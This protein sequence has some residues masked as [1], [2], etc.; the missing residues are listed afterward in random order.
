MRVHEVRYGRADSPCFTRTYTDGFGDVIREER[1]GAN[2]APLVT[3]QRTRLSGLTLATNSLTIT[4]DILGNENIVRNILAPAIQ[5]SCEIKHT[6]GILNV[7]TNWYTDGVMVSNISHSGVMTQIR[8]DALRRETARIDGR[9]NVSRIE[10]DGLGRVAA[11]IDALTN[12]TT[13][14]YDAMNRV[15]AITNALGDADE[16]H[17]A[18]RLHLRR[19]EASRRMYALS[20]TGS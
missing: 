19:G 9:G 16:R 15:A 1:S 3:A 17:L 6:P 7:A 14:A 2:G 20:P 11:T 10:Y 13:Y 4:T 12:A 8:R 5:S 18:V